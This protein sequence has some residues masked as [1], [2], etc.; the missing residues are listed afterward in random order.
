MPHLD[1]TIKLFLA[2]VAFAC[3][4]AAQSE[5]GAG[6]ISGS[7]MD[8][9]GAAVAGARV[10]ATSVATGFQRVAETT[11]GGIFTLVRLPAG[12]YEV[13][14]EKQGFKTLR[15]SGVVVNVGS[16]TPLDARLE[17]GAVSESITVTSEVGV[18]ETSRSQTSTVVEEKL[19]RD[20]PINGRNFLDFSTLTPGVVRDPRG[21]DLSFG[22]QR[23]TVNS[24]LIDGADSNNLFFGQSTGRQGV[25]NPYSVSMDAVQEFQVNTNS[26]APEIGRAAAGVVNVITKS[27]TNELHGTGFFF[28]RDTNLNANNAINKANNRPR[29]P[30]KFR[31]FGGNLGGPLAGR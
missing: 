14:V 25:R 20:L 4:A 22:G 15:R 13:T 31:Q 9:S 12:V 2:G 23:G 5:A 27:G 30:Y 8:P 3:M 16:V 26:Y 24:F 29:A 1:K 19:V 18:V 10:T 17:I 21:G 28:Y 6:T 7:A 11:E